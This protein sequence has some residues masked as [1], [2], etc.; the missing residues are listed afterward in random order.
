[1]TSIR[2]SPSG[3]II[4]G[5][6][7]GAGEQGIPGPPG[8][9]GEAGEAGPAVPG[10]PGTPGA[11]GVAGQPGPPGDEGEPGEAGPVVPGPPGPQGVAG[12]QGQP[13]QPG[14][15]GDDGESPQPML[16]MGMSPIGGA[17]QKTT[18][19]ASSG[20]TVVLAGG[21]VDHFFPP[22]GAGS[23]DYLWTG[24][25]E[26][27]LSAGCKLTYSGPP[28]RVLV[29]LEASYAVNIE[30]ATCSIVISHNDDMV[31][32]DYTFTAPVAAGQ[33]PN[34]NAGGG[35]EFSNSCSRVLDLGTGST[36]QPCLTAVLFDNTITVQTLTLSI[37][38]LN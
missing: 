18:A 3:P 26:F 17:V 15:D 24:S 35:S 22:S 25:P 34:Q 1:M 12:Q 16:V 6:V 21:D 13:G 33:M 32:S 37:I 10:P 20:G 28:R 4:G 9:E 14:R 19:T 8:D 29:R 27:V 36:I 11:Q 5:I 30:F 7:P 2:L 38:S 23:S 31:G